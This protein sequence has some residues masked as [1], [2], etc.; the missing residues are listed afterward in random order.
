[1]SRTEDMNTKEV[2]ELLKPGSMDLEKAAAALD[3]M[4][5]QQRIE[6]ITGLG[7]GPQA[8][9]FEE[10]KGRVMT[11]DDV[12]PPGTS[13]LTEVIHHGKNSLPLFTLFQK[14]FCRSADAPETELWGYNH[15]AMAAVTGP[16]YFVCHQ[17]GDE[18]AIDYTRLPESKPESWPDIKPNSAGLSRLVYFNMIDYLRKISTH[19]SIGRAVK[20]GKPADNWFLLCREDL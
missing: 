6:V 8:A 12:V 18:V 9:L 17:H 14:R 11:I 4:T 3:D 16:G 7:K 5:H 2:M 10:T 20:G 1:M 13:P 19:V 15:Q